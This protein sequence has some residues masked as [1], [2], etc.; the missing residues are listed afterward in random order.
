M[1]PSACWCGNREL[2]SFGH[3][4][5]ECSCGT[6]VRVDGP[7]SDLARVEDEDRD[8]YGKNYWFA[9]QAA[10]GLP[11]LTA[12]SVS[13]LRDRCVHWLRL[14]LEYKR[15]PGRTLEL[16]AAHGGFVSLLAA[17]G[18]DATGL[19]LSPWVVEYARHTS[20]ARMMLGPLEQHHF[21]S[22]SFDL[23]LAFD[24][25]EHLPNPVDTLRRCA[26]LLRD[27]GLLVLQTPC[28]QPDVDP[29]RVSTT[30][31]GDML[32]AEHL[33][34]FSLASARRLLEQVGLTCVVAEPSVF[35]TDMTLVAGRQPPRKCPSLSRQGNGIDAVPTVVQALLALDDALRHERAQQRQQVASLETRYRDADDDR[36]ARLQRIGELE[37]LFAQADRDREQR[38]RT[39]GELET[40]FAQADRDRSERLERI[41]MLEARYREADRDREQRLRTIGELE[42]LLS[43]ADRDRT[44]RLKRIGELEHLLTEADRNRAEGQL[45]IGTLEHQLA[46]ADRDR[47]ERL[48]RIGELE[49]LYRQADIDRT[50]RLRQLQDIDARYR[51]ADDDRRDRLHQIEQ[52]QREH[53]RLAGRYDVLRAVMTDHRH[54]RV[55]RAM[56]R[57][58][59][60]RRLEATVEPLLQEMQSPSGWVPRETREA[61]WTIPS[62]QA[63]RQRGAVAIDL[64][65]I[66]PGGEN[67]GAKLVASE[68]VRGLSTVA[69]SRQFVVLTSAMSHHEVASLDAPNVRRRTVDLAPAALTDLVDEEQLGVMFCPMTAAPFDDPRLP[70]VSLVHDLQFMTYPEFF[71]D[72]ERQS[73]HN[74]FT[75][76]MRLSD[77]VVTPSQYVR[78]TILRHSNLSEDDVTAIPHGF[79]QHRL[80]PATEQQVVETLAKYG[81]E[82]E[83]YFLYP[84]NFWLHKNHRMLLVAFAQ[85]RERRPD[86]D[87]RLVLTGASRPDPRTVR[88]SVTRM[89]IADRVVM[90]GYLPDAEL[91]ALLSGALGLVLPSLYEGFGMPVLEAFA[92]DCPVACSNVTSLPEVAGEAAV[93]FDP[94]R[95]DAI[96]DALERLATRPE[97]RRQLQLAGRQRLEHVEPGHRTACAYLSVI[98]RVTSKPRRAKDQIG[99]VFSDRWT[100]STLVIAHAGGETELQLEIEN[101]RDV[102]VTLTAGGVEPISLPPQC[103]LNLRA[104]LPS[105]D[106]HVA[107]AI[108]PTFR[109]AE[110]GNSTDMRRLGVQ[111]RSCRLHRLGAG[112]V[113]LLERA[114][115]V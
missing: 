49:E 28:R 3:G 31:F 62:L 58:G 56:V 86:L 96:A 100:T 4:Y 57:A 63:G 46:E 25:L 48:Q 6:L 92:A 1:T 83:R 84:A 51:E 26:E 94:R 12:R 22:A 41:E 20:G 91:G 45:R 50:S 59:R 30:R 9:H 54:S 74:A 61:R 73:R 80:Q 19:E 97:L 107:I 101:R 35:S 18:F 33:Y 70:L 113:D 72:G 2:Q 78:T 23:I 109:P 115:D 89:R 85:L 102:T 32:I 98:D 108:D 38:L 52:L 47:R 10:L 8:F 64:T 21:E 77:H 15:P 112:P 88:E 40:L 114:A 103:A 65:A 90:P 95:P 82:C 69:P 81:L 13:D 93:Y 17:A 43:E 44:Q 55:Y 5:M 99:G 71:D 110:S 39:I 7:S 105:T 24:V 36:I 34:L 60:W 67:G 68:L 16:G 53:A 29:A 42:Q 37:A 14:A 87:L 75:R 104:A 106:G 11:D 76:A 79:A 27:D 66:L 111:V